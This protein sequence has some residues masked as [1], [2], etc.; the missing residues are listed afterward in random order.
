MIF[1]MFVVRGAEFIKEGWKG[2]PMVTFSVFVALLINI[3]IPMCICNV[4]F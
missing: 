2:R 3:Y 4:D 1:L